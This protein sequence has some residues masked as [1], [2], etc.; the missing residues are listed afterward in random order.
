MIDASIFIGKPIPFNSKINI[1][2]PKVKDVI[3]NRNYPFYSSIFTISQEDI[4]D[5]I[6]EQQGK[7][8]TG[9]PIENAVTPFEY[10]LL[11]YYGSDLLKEK[12]IEA[13]YFWTGEKV[14]IYPEK[15]KILFVSSLANAK[16]PSDLMILTEDNY[17]NFQ[18]CIRIAENKEI[19]EPPD[20]D[21]NPKVAMIKA[22][23]RLREKIKNKHGNKSNIPISKIIVA[24]CCM[25]IGLN[26][27]NIGEIP[28]PC[29]DEIFKMMQ[30]KEKYEADF[31]IATSGFN[32]KKIYPKYW[33]NNKNN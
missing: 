22:K 16:S 20:P 4:W 21:I 10:L 23:G 29:I 18:N 1:N 28:Y 5:R 6:A 9:M 7:E 11:N 31:K 2:V 12:I 24:L 26:P 13:F 14:R 30:D 33:I 17:F 32:T 19:L 3:G 25:G 15:K 8:I 27:L